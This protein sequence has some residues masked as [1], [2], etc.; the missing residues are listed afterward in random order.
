MIFFLGLIISSSKI[1]CNSLF[2]ETTSSFVRDK[3]KK[4]KNF[5]FCLKAKSVAK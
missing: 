2:V 5:M 3:T 4:L 1:L